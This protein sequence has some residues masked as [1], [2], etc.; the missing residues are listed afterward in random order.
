MPKIHAASASASCGSPREAAAQ[1]ERA[2]VRLA[3]EVDGELRVV[4]AAREEDEQPP[5]VALV[6]GGEAVGIQS[7]RAGHRD[8]L[9]ASGRSCDWALP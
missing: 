6:G 7:A 2:G 3:D 9:V 4:R 5:R 8:D 1:L